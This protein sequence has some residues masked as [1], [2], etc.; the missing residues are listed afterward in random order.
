MKKSLL[1]TFVLL[2]F[3]SKTFSKT[4]SFVYSEQPISFIENNVSFA[5]YKNG[6]FDF[7]IDRVAGVS[8]Q[9]NTPHV[10]LSFNN[11]YNYNPYVQYDRYGAVIQVENVPIYYDHYG[12]VSQIGAVTVRYHN[13]WVQRVGGMYVYYNSYG[14][15]AHYSGYIN[16]YNRHYRHVHHRYFAY[17]HYDYL[18][19]SHSP[20]R[21]HYQP[22]RYVYHR[23]HHKNNY[24]KNKNHSY[25]AHNSKG[26]RENYSRRAT[27]EIPKRKS[28]YQR[29]T[30]RSNT[31]KPLYRDTP[32]SDESVYRRTASS[33]SS[34][35][36]VQRS[37]ETKKNT[38]RTV[39]TEPVK[40]KPEDLFRKG[41]PERRSVASNSRSSRNVQANEKKNTQRTTRDLFP[42]SK[43]QRNKTAKSTRS[44][45]K[46]EIVSTSR[47]NSSERRA[48]NKKPE[49]LSR[50]RTKLN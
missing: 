5:V 47:K 10:S 49:H 29:V 6:A 36:S 14:S 1:F 48:T 20:Y 28:D 15:Y 9:V 35:G 41:S 46:R 43:S 50:N 26:K 30:K 21:K 44:S 45:Q 22:K 17:P 32:I 4:T 7:Y 11:G 19:V 40:R 2:A 18:V 39:R 3:V 8:I 31:N 34:R 42:E 38:S 23:N 13:G 16:H 33:S 27:Q 25:Y 24:Y 37:A 12:R